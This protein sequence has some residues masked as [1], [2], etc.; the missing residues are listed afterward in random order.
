[1]RCVGQRDRCDEAVGV[2]DDGGWTIEGT[3]R[4]DSQMIAVRGRLGLEEDKISWYLE[5]ILLLLAYS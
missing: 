4:H 5:G 3:G 2:D 1:V